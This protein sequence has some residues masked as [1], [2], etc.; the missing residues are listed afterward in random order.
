M[1]AFITVNVGLLFLFYFYQVVYVC[2]C[3]L[4]VTFTTYIHDYNSTKIIKIGKDLTDL[5][6]NVDCR[7]FIDHGV[8]CNS[9]WSA[10]SAT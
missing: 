1:V 3:T 4:K 2:V 9:V 6:S 8:E 10:E 5:H 7:V